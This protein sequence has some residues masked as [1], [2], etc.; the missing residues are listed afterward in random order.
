MNAKTP[1]RQ[2][3]GNLDSFRRQSVSVSPADL[4]TLSSLTAGTRLPL[5]IKAAGASLSLAEWAQGNRDFILENLL[6][7]GG[8]LF[9]D[10]VVASAAE[11]ER[12]LTAISGRLMEYAYSSTPR[13]NV[14]G[15]IYTSTEYPADQFIPLHNEMSYARTWPLKIGFYCVTPAER[16]GETPIADSRNVLRRV[17]PRLRRRFTEKRV[18]YV[19]N[20]GERFDLPWQQVFRTTSKAEAESYC[21]E[22]GI[23]FE[24]LGDNGLRTWQDCQ[25]VARHPVTADEVWF[26][27]AH[28]FHV[29]SLAPD[30]RESMLAAFDEHELPRNACYGDGAPISA[31]D[32]EEIRD[33]YEQETISF[34]WQAGDALL[35]D[36]MLVAHGRRAYA[37]ERRVLVGMAERYEISEVVK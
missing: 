14:S 26:N 3:L 19:R 5:V 7:H 29:S 13:T 22:A 10:F 33:A 25:A 34:P 16:G 4:I 36:N 30:V 28:L 15:R 2:S 8:I 37:G 17:T 20:Y 32:L 6:G 9:R 31:D 27:Q 21:R 1:K 24:W 23:N 11:L 18:R 12:F 35:L